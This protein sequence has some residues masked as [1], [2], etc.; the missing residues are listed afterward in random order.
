MNLMENHYSALVNV[1]ATL[2]T[3]VPPP[4]HVKARVQSAVKAANNNIVKSP[5]YAEQR[6]TFKRIAALKSGFTD[7]GA[8]D[9]LKLA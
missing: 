5:E 9:T 6:E 1:K 4:K 2:N 3:R 8:P 7:H